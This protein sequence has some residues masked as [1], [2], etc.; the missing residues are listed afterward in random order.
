MKFW[1]MLEV[2]VPI[3]AVKHSCLHG[4]KDPSVL[5]LNPEETLASQT[6]L[7]KKSNCESALSPK[8]NPKYAM[9]RKCIRLKALRSQTKRDEKNDANHD[10]L[11]ETVSKFFRMR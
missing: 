11:R 2:G 3:E 8:Y 10:S 5:D 4:G 7:S 1:K 6:R 9:V